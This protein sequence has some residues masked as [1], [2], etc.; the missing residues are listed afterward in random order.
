MDAVLRNDVEQKEL[1]AAVITNY[2]RLILASKEKMA[3]GDV[4]GGT[5]YELNNSFN[6]WTSNSFDVPGIHV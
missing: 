4:N 3:G 5:G 1:M 2:C 6:V